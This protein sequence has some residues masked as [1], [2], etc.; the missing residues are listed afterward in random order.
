MTGANSFSERSPSI[1]PPEFSPSVASMASWRDVFRYS[2]ALD[3]GAW[4]ETL[5]STWGRYTPVVNNQD[6]FVAKIRA[7]TLYGFRAMHLMQNAS[8]VRRTQRDA[9]IDGMDHYYA[10]FSVSGTVKVIQNDRIVELSS[11]QAL[12]IDSAKSVAYLAD[13]EG[14]RNSTSE[15]DRTRIEAHQ[16]FV[17][18][19][20]RQS[21]VAHLGFEP[22]YGPSVHW[23]S[24]P[25]GLLF[26]LV[27]DALDDSMSDSNSD[28]MRLVIYDL[29]GAIFSP[30]DSVAFF[31]NDKLFRRA[32]RVVTD[33]FEDPSI[34][35][36][37]VAAAV[38][39]SR[40]YLQKLFAMRNLTYTHFLNSVRLDHAAR[41]L[42]RR[43]FLGRDQPI[44][45]VAY[46]CG[47]SNYTNFARQ[48]RN[49]FGH[50]PATHAKSQDDHS[51]GR[52]P[53][54]N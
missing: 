22:H 46:S 3:V 36:D 17:L 26:K 25:G 16:C 9:R 23:N 29:I 6:S 7:Q 35:P 43:A 49:R 48:F 51:P 40:R 4:H 42:R 27:G 30:P 8:L 54:T 10:I 11:G 45:A 13:Q 44:S 52:Y 21:L 5:H 18:Q 31:R 37:D 53:P 20:P 38:G 1:A 39:I 14:R 34:T 15:T 32:C 19:L 24:R 2:Q 33:R 41:L 47:F 50:A 28:Y 12:L